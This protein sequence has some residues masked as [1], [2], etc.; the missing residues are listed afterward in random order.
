MRLAQ[1]MKTRTLRRGDFKVFSLLDS[2]G[3]F[4]DF[5]GWQGANENFPS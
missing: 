1:T 3:V 4:D 2:F 5:H